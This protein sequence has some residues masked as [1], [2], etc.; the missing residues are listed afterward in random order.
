MAIMTHA[1][2][3]FNRLIVTLIFLASG[4]VSYPRAWRTTENAGPDRLNCTPEKDT[5][6]Y[7]AYHHSYS[8]KHSISKKIVYLLLNSNRL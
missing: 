3:H 2:F 5:T 6:I 8:S 7:I 4:P 1:K